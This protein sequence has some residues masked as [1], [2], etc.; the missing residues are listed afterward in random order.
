LARDS[1]RQRGA[2]EIRDDAGEVGNAAIAKH[3]TGT[4]R[5]HGA[6]SYEFQLNPLE[7]TRPAGTPDQSVRIVC[8]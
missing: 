4:L 8:R 6:K 2:G 1:G 7:I 5:A 3:E